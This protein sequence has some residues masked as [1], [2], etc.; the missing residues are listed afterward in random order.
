MRTKNLLAVV[1]VPNM[2]KL[3]VG[4]IRHY[5][6]SHP[7]ANETLVRTRHCIAHCPLLLLLLSR[8]LHRPGRISRLGFQDQ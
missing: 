6:Q 5:H 8:L 1:P 7:I 4:Y 3:L 2:I